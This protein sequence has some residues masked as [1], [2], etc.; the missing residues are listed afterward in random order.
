MTRHTY[1]II[2]MPSIRREDALSEVI[3]FIL[4]LA[5][6]T[7]LISL[8]LVYVV[9]AEGRQNEIGHMNQ[10]NY[11][12]SQYK[13]AIDSLIINEQKDLSIYNTFTLSTQ[14]ISSSSGGLFIL[15]LF[16]PAGSS[17]AILI[18]QRTDN[19]E[20][21]GELLQEYAG[22]GNATPNFSVISGK[23]SHIYTNFT[24]RSIYPD[25]G[26]NVSWV[27]PNSGF[28]V[29]PLNNPSWKIWINHTPRV[30]HVSV[31]R[32][33]YETDLTVTVEKNGL[34][35]IQ[36]LII[37]KNITNNT[38]YYVDLVDPTY[39]LGDV[40][41][42]SEVLQ[43]IPTSAYIEFEPLATNYGYNSTSL[44]EANT[45]G[46]LEFNSENNYFINQD[47]YYQMGGIFLKQD[48]GMVNKI[49]PSITL[50]RDV[51]NITYV[52]ID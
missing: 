48:D 29:I 26:L 16:Q 31:E 39:G 34:V 32:V 7:I 40:L 47:Y 17:G 42:E 27:P 13:T 14:Q 36:E 18:N 45:L 1:S 35:T 20:I 33:N 2:S 3:G 6:I 12:F 5:I 50:S 10:I 8:Y 49:T 51:D 46:S 22:L 9:P 4:I 24:L 25:K 30:D 52:S 15:P 23:P 19:I 21:R 38:R 41:Q 44:V 37:Q 43:R 28:M 11:Q